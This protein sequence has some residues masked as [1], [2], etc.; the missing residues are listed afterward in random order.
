MFIAFV[1]EGYASILITGLAPTA[2]NSCE[3]KIN[4]KLK[5]CLD[6]LSL[7]RLWVLCDNISVLFGRK[8]EEEKYYRFSVRKIMAVLSAWLE[9]VCFL[10]WEAS[11]VLKT[12]RE[13]LHGSLMDLSPWRWSFYQTIKVSQR[14]HTLALATLT[15]QMRTWL[16]TL[17]TQG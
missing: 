15:T 6:P 16:A 4:V 12:D 11:L 8:F 9:D 13:Y 14:S 5:Q 10:I 2:I 7:C 3:C 1:Q 17:R